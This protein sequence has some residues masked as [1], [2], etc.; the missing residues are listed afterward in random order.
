[1]RS[2]TAAPSTN[3]AL[4]LSRTVASGCSTGTIGGVDAHADRA[5]VGLLGDGEE[6][7][8]VAQPPGERDVGRGDAGM[9]SWYTS[10]A[11]TRDAERD[12]GDDGGLG[13][14]VVALDVG[15]RVALGVAERLGLGQGVGVAT[16]PP[17]SSG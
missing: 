5:G 17:R 12:A 9:P 11:T 14:G 8:D 2:P 3:T 10:P 1:M 13:A 6:L 7:D 15:G 4:K 16:R